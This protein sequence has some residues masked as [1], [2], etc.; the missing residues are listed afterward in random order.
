MTKKCHAMT[1]R[2]YESDKKLQRQSA[3]CVKV[4][5]IAGNISQYSTKYKIN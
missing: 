1:S 5:L 4:N 3:G 2:G